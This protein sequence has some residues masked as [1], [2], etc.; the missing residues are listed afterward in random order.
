MLTYTA[1]TSYVAE[2]FSDQEWGYDPRLAIALW[3]RMDSLFVYASAALFSLFLMS[4]PSAE[5]IM[6]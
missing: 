2:E 4:W 6:M 3:S 5:F 1:A